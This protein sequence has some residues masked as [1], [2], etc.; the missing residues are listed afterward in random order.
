MD[1]SVPQ[2]TVEDLF[3]VSSDTAQ[4][5]RS[6]DWQR[7]P[8]GPVELWPQSLK[9]SLSICL[10]SAFPILVWWGPE[11]V[12]LYNDAYAPIISNKHPGALGRPGKEIFPEV[13]DTIGPMLESVL[14]EGKAVRADDLLLLLERRGYPEECYFT[15]SYSPILDETGGVGGVFTPV[16][17]TTERVVNER[18]L[19]ALSTVSDMRAEQA[20][21]VGTACRA[22]VSALE[23]DRT[24]L[25]FF[26]I[27]I[28]N[29]DH[30][31]ARR[32]AEYPGGMEHLAPS[33]ATAHASWPPLDLLAR[34]QTVVR[35]TG[36]LP[37]KEIPC[38]SSGKRI[39]QIVAMTLKQSGSELA[40][41]FLI[42]GLN[43]RKRLDENY[44][45]FLS[46]VA[47][48]LSGAVADAEAFEAERKRA[49]A[50]A[51]IDRAKTVFFSNISH[52]FRTP[53]TLMSGPIQQVLADAELRPELR[54]NLELAHRNTTRLQKL[55][56]NLLDFSRIEAGKARAQFRPLDLVKFTRGL[57]G[58]FE[59]TFN[60]AG[61]YL[62]FEADPIPTVY[63]DADH[64][65]KVVLNLLSNAF[66]FTL[67]GGVTVRLLQGN[68]FAH[69]IVEDTGTGIPVDQLPKIFQR[70]H[71]V[72]GAVGRSFEGSGIGLALVQELV[73]LHAGS[74]SVE[75]QEGVGTKFIVQ[76]PL[77]SDHLRAE[78]VDDIG[79]PVAA[80]DRVDSF[81][82]EAMRWIPEHG[83]QATVASEILSSSDGEPFA[84]NMPPSLDR[85]FVL[86]AD[87]NRD[88]RE[89]LERL[90]S[91][92]FEVRTASNGIE[93]LQL[94]GQSRPDL[95]LSDVMMPIVDGLELLKLLRKDPATASIPIILLSARAGEEEQIE[96]LKSGADDYLIKP[97][98]TRELVARV[99]SALKIT[100]IRAAGEKALRESEQELRYTVEFNFQVPW[101]ADPE[102][103]TIDFNNRWL[104]ITGMTRE[105][106]LGNGW[107]RVQH[108]DDL[109][110]V[111][112]SWS[113][114]IRTGEPL[115]IEHRVRG[116]H[117]VYRWMRSR[118]MARRDG[119]GNIVKWYGT[120][121]DIDDRKR[122]EEKLLESERRMRIAQ[123][124]A[125]VLVWEWCTSTDELIWGPGV[126]RIY[127]RS[128][129]ELS[130]GRWAEAVHPN[131]RDRIRRVLD[132]VVT[133]GLPYDAEYRVVWPDGSVHFLIAKGE[134]YRNAAN[135]YTYLV[136]ANVD[137]T[138]RKA[139]E[140][141]L[142]E[143]DL[144]IREVLERTS[145]A[146]FLLDSEWRF[147]YLNPNAVKL[148]ASDRDLLGKNI[149]HEF[150]EAVERNFYRE[151]HRA[152]ADRVPVQFEEFYPE[153]LKKW[154]EV[155]AYPTADGLAVF[156]R[157]VTLKKKSDAA[158]I[159]SEKLA[160]AG[161]LAASIA[162]EIN[163]P[164]EAVTNLLFL[165][166]TNASLDSHARH[167]VA[168]AQNEVTRVSHIARQTL[169]FYRQ[170]TNATDVRIDQL[171]DS[172]IAIHRLRYPDSKIQVERRYQPT[173]AFKA[174]EGELR[175]VFSNLM[176]NASDAVCP[177]G[178]IVL[179]ARRSVDWRSGRTG[180]RVT[181]ADDGQGMTAEVMQHLF[182]PFFSTKGMIGTGLGLWVSREI[183]ERHRGEMRVRS[184]TSLSRQGTTFSVFIPEH[185]DSDD[186][187][188]RAR[189]SEAAQDQLANG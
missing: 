29:E 75:S 160:A 76:I 88:M 92:Q 126:E 186:A 32:V 114:S 142:R 77:G 161:R 159:Q 40:K 62:K 59:S 22:L 158:L 101:T 6:L 168:T 67:S 53:L 43:P 99:S 46:L 11:L 164:L 138:A 151:Y 89:Y 177:D 157:D 21:D 133:K 146:V 47:E 123:E 163:N 167:F 55:V 16:H 52:E 111:E 150:P 19:K 173:P 64:W 23:E 49:E 71:R 48:H 79:G 78:Q 5:L 34:G 149:W 70:F 86:I 44:A 103:H 179:R 102:G 84:T 7:T 20:P 128:A 31:V 169:G 1:S 132:E 140:E 18:R 148:I 139:V 116:P 8:L 25:P 63:V 120:E 152:L 54:E 135:G 61:L 180:I 153:P 166:G 81:L 121:E 122:A 82:Q 156:F 12:M 143:R 33:Q 144:Q 117:G 41:G 100:D 108:P 188:A 35:D 98:S 109:E 37:E 137:I 9:T 65:E 178:R 184:S 118:A 113:H 3:P 50:L 42:A 39:E 96:G 162:H 107:R 165:L 13:W 155:H 85:K 45:S 2:M 94:I 174:L 141:A 57:V 171:L 51:E 38:G 27:Y 58:S 129:N 15:F 87:D 189:V 154:F 125:G 17:E 66:K 69:L 60:K 97:F 10:N 136:G 56:N 36:F 183:V 26:A 28:F 68:G 175:Q 134:I 95:V 72:E 172:V 112:A 14:H 74:I 119:D 30:S 80:S 93:A 187:P 182:E 110:R 127:G 104:E 185:K 73:K 170:S 176:S 106:A 181:V 145:D 83:E 147:Q 91:S 130:F 131:D 4:L 24:D 90:L 115:D 105:E 124:A